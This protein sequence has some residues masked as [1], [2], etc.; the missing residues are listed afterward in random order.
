MLV[1][2]LCAILSEYLQPGIITQAYISLRPRIERSYKDAP[3]NALSQALITLFRI[4]TLAMALCLSICQDRTFTFLVYLSV[5][6]LIV[7]VLALKMLCNVMVDHTFM[8]S[9]RFMPM[10]E[11]YSNIFTVVTILLYPCLLV[12]LRVDNPSACQWILGI[13]MALF[14]ALWI[15]RSARIFIISPVAILYFILYIVTLELLP[16]GALLYLSSQTILYI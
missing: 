11:H 12:V 2:L 15:Y 13:T 16:I 7:A 14:I 8:L 3:S 10:Y 6:A 4:G 9:R 1:L 5:C